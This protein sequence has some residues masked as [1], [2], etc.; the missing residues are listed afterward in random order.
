LKKS[1]ALGAIPV[2]VLSARDPEAN[3]ARVL[4]AGANAY[5]HKPADMPELLDAIRMQLTVAERA[6]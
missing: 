5:F 1:A 3:R 2:I 4:K 6:S